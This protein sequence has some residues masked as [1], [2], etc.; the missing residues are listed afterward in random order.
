MLDTTTEAGGRA[1]RRL[2]EE[3]IIWQTTVRSDGQPQSVPVWLFW[4]GDRFLVYSQPYRQK[5][6]NI[7]REPRVGL[8]LTSNARVG[9]VLSVEGTAAIVEDAPPATG[10]PEYVEKYRGALS[11]SASTRK[12]SR[13]PSRWHSGSRQRAGRPGS[14][15]LG[16]GRRLEC[17]FCPS[18]SISTFSS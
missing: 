10:V 12:A 14:P 2:R 5:L 9:D 15:N 13:G 18:T 11:G 3:Q 7:E 16:T 6:R 17:Y 8:N 4:D 1:E